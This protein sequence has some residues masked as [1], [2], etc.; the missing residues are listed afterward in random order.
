[1]IRPLGGALARAV[2]AGRF[3]GAKGQ[4]LELL[5]P[6]GVAASRVLLVGLGA[7]S[8]VDG[9]AVE[10]GSASAYQAL[11]LSAARPNC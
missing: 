2:A 8:A 7:E 5:A 6:Q 4:T 11:K 1:L 9:A 10:A 3:N